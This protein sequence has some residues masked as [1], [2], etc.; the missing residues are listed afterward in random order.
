[1]K[2]S[3]YINNYDSKKN[4]QSF[5][6]VPKNPVFLPEIF[7]KIGKV[8]AYN[9]RTPEQKLFMAM[10]ALC[11]QPLIDL[12]FAA[13]D[14]KT[15]AAI[16]S[17]SKAVACGVTGVSL[18]AIFQKASCNLIGFDKHNVVNDLFLPSEALELYKSYPEKATIKL[19]EYSKV[20]GSIAA[21]A[22]MVFYSNSK[23][24]VPLTS[25]FQDLISGVVKENKSWSKS[26]AEVLKN[27][28]NKISVWFNKKKNNLKNIN[29]KFNKIIE[30][31]LSKNS[32][33]E[34]KK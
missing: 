25:D 12:K 24:D 8:A 34:S 10:F 22:F 16:K 19:Q 13:E 33:E 30:I 29:N 7:G 23:W 6:G 11:F 3:T 18:R 9:I 28:K 15:D 1:M 17:A 31:F 21:I 5:K 14:K 27:R 20:L 32:N 4:C 2:I 26:F